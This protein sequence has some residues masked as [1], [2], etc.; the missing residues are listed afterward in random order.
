MLKYKGIL[1]C[2]QRSRLIISALLLRVAA[3]LLSLPQPPLPSLSKLLALMAAGEEDK[4][5]H[6]TTE[7]IAEAIENWKE[8]NIVALY[9]VILKLMLWL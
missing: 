7:L 1:W 8:P 6:D 9:L 2:W 4:G 3:K 5:G